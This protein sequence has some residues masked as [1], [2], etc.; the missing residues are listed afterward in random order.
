MRKYLL[1]IG[2]MSLLIMLMSAC[3]KSNITAV[4]VQQALQKQGLEVNEINIAKS[5]NDHDSDS[6][7][8]NGVF[9][10]AYQLV[11]PA[12]DM[13]H[14]EYV[15]VYEYSSVDKS[16]SASQSD[17]IDSLMMVDLHPNIHQKKNVVVIYWYENEENPLMIKQFTKAMDSL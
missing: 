7:Q 16:M 15:F 5:E 2:A 1:M 11:L 10:K 9:P 13:A 12:A 4:N 14:D 6:L 17:M 3:E 8:L